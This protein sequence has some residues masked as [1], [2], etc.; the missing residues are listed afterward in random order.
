MAGCGSHARRTQ[1]SGARTRAQSQHKPSRQHHRWGARPGGL[2][3]FPHHFPHLRHW[4]GLRGLQMVHTWHFMLRGRRRG[5]RARWTAAARRRRRRHTGR[6]YWT[7]GF[8][9]D[10]IDGRDRGRR[11]DCRGSDRRRTERKDRR[12]DGAGGSDGR[13]PW[14]LRR[15]RGSMFGGNRFHCIPRPC[16]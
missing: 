7:D 6:T 11:R 8:G 15:P 1:R 12:K 4:T 9:R 2:Q 16:P 14:R 5:G 13:T 10:G 3:P